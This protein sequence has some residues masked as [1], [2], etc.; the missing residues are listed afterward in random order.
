[1]RITRLLSSVFVVV[2][3]GTSCTMSDSGRPALDDSAARRTRS[4][5]LTRLQVSDVPVPPEM[6][7]KKR[8]NRSFSFAG[9]GVRVAHLVYRGPLSIEDII[10]FYEDTMPLAAFGWVSAGEERNNNEVILRFTKN[11]DNCEIRVF[12][13]QDT[14]TAEVELTGLN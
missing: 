1:M 8:G 2:V 6:R 3:L 11:A 10:S 7:L 12:R 4:Q 9:G 5:Q 14:A 13:D